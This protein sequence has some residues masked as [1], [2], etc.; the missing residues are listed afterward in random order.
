DAQP[1]EHR[2]GGPGETVTLKVVAEFADG[3][4]ED[5]T[6][7]C[8]FRA[9]DDYIADV[10]PAGAVRGLHPGDTAVVI[11]YRGNLATARALVPAPA[12]PS[13]VYPDLPEANF[14]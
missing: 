5:V 2:F 7:F 9:K 1:R 11:S 10:T 8:E 4:R 13:F 12:A 3:S 6:P 14:I